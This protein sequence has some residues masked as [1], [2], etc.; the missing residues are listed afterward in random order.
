MLTFGGK[1]TMNKMTTSEKIAELRR[2]MLR[3]K[4]AA[5]IISGTDPHNSEYLPVTWQQRKWFSGFTGSYGTIVVTA[6]HVGLWTDTRY[7]IQALQELRDTE[8]VLHKLR[9]PDAVDY[10][11]WLSEQLQEGDQVGVDAFCM[12][13][14]E[15]RR[16]QKAFAAKKT[17]LCEKIDLLGEIWLDRPPLPTGKLRTLGVDIVGESTTD[18][19]RRVQNYLNRNHGDYALFTALDEIAWLY[20]IRCDDIPYNPVAIAYALVEPRKAHLFVKTEKLGKNEEEELREHG[21]EIHDY[22]HVSLFLDEIEGKPTFFVDVATCNYA[23]YSQL[24]R[25]FPVV[26][27]TSP[28]VSWKAVKNATE[29]SGFRLACR[30]DGVALTKFF[31]WLENRMK[32]QPIRELEAASALT[33]F[34]RAGDAYASDSFECISAYGLNAALPHYSATEHDQVELQ[35]RG[36][37]LVDSGA[38]YLHGTTD[39]TRTIPL[40][41][42]TDTEKVDYT[43]VL[44]G[45]INLS[46]LVFPKG[47]KG[48]NMDI[49]AR[50][51]LYMNSRNYGHGTGH[52]VGHFLNVHEGPQAIRPDLK[53]QEIVPGMVTSNEPGIYREGSHGIRH[54]NLIACRAKE[55]N[56]FGE[57]YTFDT[58]TLCYIDTSPLLHELLE[59]CEIEWLNTYHE[60]VYQ[61]AS[62][63]LTEDEKMWLRRKTQ[64]I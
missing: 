24:N 40:G 55:T 19:I 62:P 32:T 31:Y 44:K 4:L 45:M 33:E 18:K 5:Y 11:Q 6:N 21:I 30:K 8:I 59:S 22:H 38:Q 50:L 2:I 35:P 47:C 7:F 14:T 23:L 17:V 54:E 15:V 48:C 29:L 42:L 46:R 26:E 1:S 43:L 61:E 9:I 12:T 53:E 25:L 37:Y 16:L 52:G 51:P 34:R 41:D 36:L 57:F 3:E 60:R 49:V 28:V 10:P 56:E 39:I 20:N 27:N 63:Y 64:A 58:L 13:V